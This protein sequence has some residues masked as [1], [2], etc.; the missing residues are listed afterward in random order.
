MLQGD[1]FFP[2]FEGAS[3]ASI[4]ERSMKLRLGG[5]AG[6]RAGLRSYAAVSNPGLLYG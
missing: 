4:L 1:F 5:E 6:H 3:V 2:Q